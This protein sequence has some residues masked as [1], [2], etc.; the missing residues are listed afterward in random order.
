MKPGHWESVS[1]TV[2]TCLGNLG[3][4]QNTIHY[5][6]LLCGHL[7]LRGRWALNQSSEAGLSPPVTCRLLTPWLSLLQGSSLPGPTWWRARGFWSGFYLSFKTTVV[8]F[9][10][11]LSETAG[12]SVLEVM[13]QGW[14]C[15]GCLSPEGPPFV[16]AELGTASLQGLCPVPPACLLL[17]RSQ[18]FLIKSCWSLDGWFSFSRVVLET[19][20]FKPIKFDQTSPSLLC[21]LNSLR[22]VLKKKFNL[23]CDNLCG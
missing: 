18:A 6:H 19:M 17:T 22:L 11:C 20:H 4:S 12:P 10:L 1:L 2:L 7:S 3:V 8:R 21:I 13:P 14:L 16:L 23:F 9:L 15:S 5:W